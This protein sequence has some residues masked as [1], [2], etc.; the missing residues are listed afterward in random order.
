[1][2]SEANKFNF[3]LIEPEGKVMDTAVSHVII[4]GEEGEFGVLVDHCHMVSMLKAGLLRVWIDDNTEPEKY[5]VSG[6]FT[7]ICNNRCVVLAREICP[8]ADLDRERLNDELND[9]R[10]KM[11]NEKNSFLVKE[12]KRDIAIV[13]SKIS[14]CNYACE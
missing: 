7:D 13:E 12:L 9:L 8:F 2:S 5:F 6:G 10:Q 11:M 1:M 3:E 4:P 14:V